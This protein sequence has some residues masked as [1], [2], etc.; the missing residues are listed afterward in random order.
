MMRLVNITRHFS[1]GHVTDN[2]TLVMQR[3]A[4]ELC[5]APDHQLS[6]N[7]SHDV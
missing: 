6:L 4:H 2:M 5:I 3:Q 7:A 1:E